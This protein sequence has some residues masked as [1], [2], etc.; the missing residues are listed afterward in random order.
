MTRVVAAA[1]GAD[2]DLVLVRPDR[3]VLRRPL[4]PNVTTTEWLPF[5]AVLPRVAGIVHHGGAGSVMS[6]LTAGVPQVVVPGAG[7]RTVHA[8][9]VAERGA[10][11]AVRAPEITAETLERLV[12]D[13]ALAAAAGEVAAEIAAMPPPGD[14]VEPLLDGV[15][16]AP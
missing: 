5:A 7:D 16:S 15:R 8:R 1:T 14:L 10:G 2:I 12:T 9:L 13:P 3:A 6:A 4:P 11:L